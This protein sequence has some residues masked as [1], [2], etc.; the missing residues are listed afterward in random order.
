MAFDELGAK[1]RHHRHRDQIGGEQRK[2]HRQRQRREQEFADAVE[3]D[4]RKENDGGREGGRQHRQSDFLAAFFGGDFGRFAHFQVAEN[5]FEHDDGVVD[6]P[7]KGQRQS[8]ENHGVDGAAA[9][10]DGQ[11]RSQRGERNG[12][13]DSERRTHAA[14]KKQES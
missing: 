4:H 11:K 5:V 14:E 3:K 13:K 2:N 9:G 7:R 8:T 10:A 1:Q 6:Q 12:K